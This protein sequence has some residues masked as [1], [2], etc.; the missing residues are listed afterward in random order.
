MEAPDS[1]VLNV[2]VHPLNLIIIRHYDGGAPMFLLIR[3][4]TAP[5]LASRELQ[6]LHQ[7]PLPAH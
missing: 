1:R 3:V 2:P 5:S 6:P 4:G 7:K